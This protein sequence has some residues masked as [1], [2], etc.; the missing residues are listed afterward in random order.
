MKG[1]AGDFATMPLQDLTIYLW[2]RRGTG[3]L[4]LEHDAT[5][6]QLLIV[7]GHVLNASSNNPREYLGQVL[8]NL[9]LI[10]EE[11]FNH[12][13]VTQKETKIFM[14]RILVMIGV[15]TEADLN[16]ALQFKYRET[17]LEAFDWKTGYFTLVSD[18]RV[19]SPDQENIRVPLGEIPKDAVGRIKVWE[20]IR[21]VFPQSDC[22][23]TADL[24]QLPEPVR[25]GSLDEKIFAALEGGATLRDLTLRLHATDF[26]LQSRLCALQRMGVISVGE[27]QETG[28]EI[29]VGTSG[30]EA[31]SINALH[32]AARDALEQ[33]SYRE[34]YHALRPAL[35]MAQTPEAMT[36]M[37]EVQ[38]RWLPDLQ[39]RLLGQRNVAILAVSPEELATHHLSPEERYLIS[40]LDG[41]R[42]IEAIVRAAPMSEFEALALFDHFLSLQWV[43]TGTTDQ[44]DVMSV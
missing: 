5:T 13:Y 22:L 44:I 21:Q 33:S 15:L 17:L 34:A 38:T 2:N 20:Q 29:E 9:G 43:F 10:T 1:L 12:A 4:T 32:E 8:I 25:P 3:T 24:S 7:D 6:K 23:L 31:E 37:A 41:N 16:A 35:Q 27:P 26:F 11:Q 14:G 42:D 28:I 36:M 40:R 19:A 39:K 18:A 30:E